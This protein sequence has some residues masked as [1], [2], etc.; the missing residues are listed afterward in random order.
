[1]PASAPLATSHSRQSSVFVPTMTSTCPAG[2]GGDPLDRRAGQDVAVD[3]GLP[4]HNARHDG[5]APS[6]RVGVG[7]QLV[8]QPRLRR[9]QPLDPDAGDR[10]TRR[11]HPQ[12]A[13]QVSGDA[14]RVLSRRD[15]VGCA[16]LQDRP[17]EQPLGAGHREQHAD[18]H[19]PGGL[20]EDRHVAGVP[21]EGSDVLPHPLQRG[22]LVEQAEVGDAVAEIEEP[23][24]ARTPVDDDTDHPVPGEAA[25]VVG[26]RRADLEHAALDPDHHRQPCS[27]GIRR[28]DVEVQ[29]F[30]GRR[31]TLHRRERRLTSV[32][33]SGAP[34]AGPPVDGGA[35]CGGSGPSLVASRTPDHGTAGC[36]GRSRFAPN[37]GAAYGTPRK[38]YTPSA[39]LPRSSPPAS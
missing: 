29:A 7:E 10:L 9:Q 22:D 17:P 19:R 28:P 32:Q 21:A 1:M 14:Q 35:T 23:L 3:D 13:G 39:K 31:G 34:V 24:R 2:S 33:S 12:P 38:V 26:R 6:F 36:G 30:L 18:A 25:A 15:L 16:A 11:G 5:R 4:R 27:A 8:L 20:A 37:G